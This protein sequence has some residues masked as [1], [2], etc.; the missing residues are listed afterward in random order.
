ML[1]GIGKRGPQRRGLCPPY[2]GQKHCPTLQ[3][4]GM[5]QMQSKKKSKNTHHSKFVNLPK[6]ESPNRYRFQIL[7]KKK[8]YI[9]EFC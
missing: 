6:L 5:E 1:I 4:G 2:S 8:I 7:R 3:G 9:F